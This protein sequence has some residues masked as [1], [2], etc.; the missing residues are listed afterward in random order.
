MSVFMKKL[1]QLK[2]NKR[3]VSNTVVGI[4][5]LGI[6]LALLAAYLVFVRGAVESSTIGNITVDDKS[7][8]PADAAQK[9]SEDA[10]EAIG[11]L[12]K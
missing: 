12:T 10:T 3:G 5:M 9:A 11:K 6:G 8:T 4:A 2:G 7:L 1:S